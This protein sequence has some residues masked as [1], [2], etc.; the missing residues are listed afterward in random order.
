MTRRWAT[1]LLCAYADVLTSVFWPGPVNGLTVLFIL[2]I[3]AVLAF[4]LL[5]L[6]SLIAAHRLVGR[7]S[8]EIDENARI[9]NAELQ[10]RRMGRGSDR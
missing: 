5:G 9:R 2:L 4:V 10:L 6:P 3:D 7:E 1:A 8:A